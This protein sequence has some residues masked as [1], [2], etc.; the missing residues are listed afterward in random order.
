MT[1]FLALIGGCGGSVRGFSTSTTPKAHG[2]NYYARRQLAIGRLPNGQ[3]F[4]IWA[5]RYRFA[6][7]EY[8]QLITST[9]PVAHSL[10]KIRQELASN[11]YG[12]SQQNINDLTA[13]VSLAGEVGCGRPP[14]VLLAGLVRA[15]VHA[16][17]FKSGKRTWPFNLV[18]LPADLGVR[19][20]VGYGFLTTDATLH[21]MSSQ[22][23]VVYSEPF[24]GPPSHRECAGGT[25]S[26]QYAFPVGH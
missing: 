21:M 4:G 22:G 7:K 6:G 11:A 24:P 19:G 8:I 9:V 16:A 1:A 3:G 26:I 20:V 23:K 25:E 12:S 13:P 18:G 14:V 10:R 17:Q 5:Q 2:R 15:P